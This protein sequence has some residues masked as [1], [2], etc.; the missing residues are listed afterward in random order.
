MVDRLEAEL[1]VAP[2]SVS[3]SVYKMFHSVEGGLS[4]QYHASWGLILN[5]IST[6]FEV[7]IRLISLLISAHRP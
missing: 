7:S 4:Y 5:I 2:K 3:T 6:F 1:S